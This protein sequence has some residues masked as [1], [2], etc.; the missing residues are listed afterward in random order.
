MKDIQKKQ[1]ICVGLILL[2]LFLS[3]SIQITYF[4]AKISPL[5][6]SS[7]AKLQGPTITNIVYAPEKP[8]WFDNIT[9]TA[10]ITDPWGIFEVWIN[11]DAQKDAYAGWTA[12]FTMT[13]DEDDLYTYS[14]LNSIWK[15]PWGPAFG[16][17]VNFTIYAKN[18]KGIWSKSNY[19]N[20]YM[21]DTVKPIAQISLN[22]NS[23]VSGIIKINTTV[24]EEGS[25]LKQQNLSIYMGNGT[26]Y[27]RFTSTNLNATFS[28]DVLILP[29]YNISK[30]SS[31]FTMNLTAWD[32]ATPFNKDTIILESIRIDN[33]PPSIA[34]I[35]SY[36]NLTAPSQDNQTKTS[37]TISATEFTN[38]ITSTYYNDS[39]YHSFYN[40]SKGFLQIA[41]GFN[42][43]NWNLTSGM[44]K[45][46]SITLEGKISYATSSILQAGWKIWSWEYNNFTIIN[47]II[48]NSTGEISDTLYLTNSNKSKFINTAFD[49][50]IEI[51]FFVNTSGPAIKA[52][53]DFIQY[54]IEYYKIDDWYN[55]E[56][57]NITL[58]IIGAD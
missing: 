15:P 46:M 54:N 37:N 26:L 58:E 57:E 18:G 29:D 22:N 19:Y 17:H 3:L 14:I 42:L 4:V 12:N 27:K 39:I 47:A 53:I 9:I 44:L 16:S 35:N 41:Y 43:T 56:N 8:E 33:N 28:W 11:Y 21:N 20:F 7:I 51:F 6:N 34:F 5:R 1:I 48:F 32:K 31:Y 52:S 24:I 23:W 50:R 38:N 2:C 13:H 36:K 30:P 49:H 10:Q 25:G 45:I 55:R 40:S